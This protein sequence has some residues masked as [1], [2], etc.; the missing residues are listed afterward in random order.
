MAVRSYLKAADLKLIEAHLAAADEV[1][2]REC[3][4][5]ATD[6]EVRDGIRVLLAKVVLQRIHAE[7][8]EHGSVSA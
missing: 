1:F 4:I 2:L 6:L 3:A 8:R 5:A 7:A